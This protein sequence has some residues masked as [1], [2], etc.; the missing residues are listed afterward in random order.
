MDN[1][2]AMGYAHTWKKRILKTTMVGYMKVLARVKRGETSR[3][4]KGKETMT[5]RRFKRLLGNQYWYRMG[6]QK[7]DGAS[8]R[9][10]S[11]NEE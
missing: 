6:E 7:V 5:S 11:R 2:S 10:D 3:N 8:I 9:E 4:R 1:L